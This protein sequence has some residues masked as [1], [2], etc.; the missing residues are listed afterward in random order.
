M[1]L[2]VTFDTNTLDK[3]ARPERFPRDPRQ[4]TYFGVHD[5]LRTGRLK[6]YFSETL[7]TLEGIEIKDRADVL[8]STRLDRQMHSNG[9]NRITLSLAVQQDRKP[10]NL[11]FSKRIQTAQ[12]I[13]LRALRGPARIGWLRI[14]DDDNTFFEPDESVLELSKRLDIAHEVATAIETRGLGR[15]IPLSLGLRF[16]ARDG[17]SE[18]WLQG[19]QR[20]RDIHE[21]NQV[22]R[23]VAEWADAD[24]VAAHRG[25]GIDLFCSEDFGKK[26]QTASV[27]DYNNRRWLSEA[28]GIRFVT[29]AELAEIVAAACQ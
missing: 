27:L 1:L 15:A 18:L 20:A 22:A 4:P 14:K 17:A 24:S 9:G 28:Y 2:R 7:V 25:Y 8:G 29:L 21:R 19:L 16:S 12:E 5:A 13:G 11:E 6:G 10:L 26:A 23:A 3:V